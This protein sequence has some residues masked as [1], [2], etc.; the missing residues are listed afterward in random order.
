MTEEKKPISMRL[1]VS[2]EQHRGLKA[3][4]KRRAVSM[5]Q[6]VRDALDKELLL[7]AADAEL[8]KPRAGSRGA[9]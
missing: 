5:A 4:A 1:F 6:I 8:P 9:R 3:E 2:K 7:N